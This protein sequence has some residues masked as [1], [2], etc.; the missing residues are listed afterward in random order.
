MRLYDQ[1]T[2]T[3]RP[4][5]PT[6]CADYWE[7]H[8][9]WD[10]H[11]SLLAL[12]TT[13]GDLLV[14]DV[15]TGRVVYKEAGLGGGIRATSFGPDS[16]R[17]IL[18]GAT[19]PGAVTVIDTRTGRRLVDLVGVA[20]KVE[21]AAYSPD[22]TRIVTGST[23]GYARIWD[24]RSGALLRAIA[25][26]NGPVLASFSDDGSRIVTVDAANDIRVFSACPG[27]QHPEQLVAIAE[28]QLTRSLSADE[29]H[30]YRG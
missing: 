4:L 30:I 24:A 16:T 15:A 1:H 7:N 8:V 11:S 17:L 25:H 13:C 20:A 22:G 28:H 26:I 5:V 10:R 9:A 14:I 2:K 29:R 21:R 6:T 23:D 3:I 27:C 12:S 18:V 19:G